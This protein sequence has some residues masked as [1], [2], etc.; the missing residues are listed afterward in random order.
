M[1]FLLPAAASAI[2][3]AAPTV[4]AASA[5]AAVPSITATLSSVAMNLAMNVAVSAAMSALQPQVGSAGRTM[6]WTLDPDGAIPFAFGRVG[7]AGSVVYRKTFGPDKMYLGVVSVLSGAGPIRSFQTFRGDE[8]FVTFDGA[9][10]A[11]SSQWVGEMWRTTRLGTQPDTALPVPIGLKTG[12]PP[13]GWT[14]SH[15]LS[16]KA[17]TLLVMG[18][19]SKRSAY[20]QGEVKPL[21]VIEGLFC[22]DPRQDSTYPG[23]FGPCRLSDPSTWPWVE[24][25]ILFGL[26][27]ALGLWEGPIGKGAPQVDHQ[28]GGIGAKLAGIDVGAFV[29]AA[30]VSDANG[31]TSAAYPTTA[32]DKAQVLD[33]FLQAGGAI[34]AQRAGKISCIQRAAPRASVATI[35]ARDVAG[36]IEID[37]A[38]SRIDRINTLRPR[39]WS[40]AHRWQMT[41]VE[42]V[43]AEAWRIEDGGVRPRGIDYPYVTDKDQVAQLAALQIANTREG[44]AGV[45]PLKPHL[46]R[47]RPGDAF[48]IDEP[49][50][51]LN[52]QKC[53]CLKTDYDPVTTIVRVTFVSE[54]DAKYAFALGQTGTPPPPAVL[55]PFDPTVTPPQPG[56]WVL[57]SELLT[58][59]GATVPALVLTGEVDNARAQSVIFEFQ[60][61]DPDN[62]TAPWADLWTGAG[63]EDPTVERKEITGLTPTPYWA[64]VSYRVGGNLSSRLVLGPVTA[65]A[66]VTPPAPAPAK[67]PGT[68][69]LTI[70]T[71]IQPDG[72]EVSALSGSWTAVAE[73]TTYDIEI[74]DGVAAW[75]ESRGT[76]SIKN[77]RV[78]TGRTYRIRVKA[79]NR[80]GV[81]STVWSNWSASVAAG[82]DSAGPGLISGPSIVALAR[83]LVLGWTNPADAD[84]SHL[85]MYRNVSGTAPTPADLYAVRVEGSTWTDTNVTAGVRYYYTA[86][87][88]D[89]SGNVG[90]QTY[91]G[92]AIPSYISTGGGDVLPTD[93]TLV[94]SVGT[95]AL[96][97]GQGT[98]ATRNSVTAAMMPLLS[99]ENDFTDED[100]DSTLIVP[101]SGASFDTSAETTATMGIKRSLKS[102]VGNGSLT[103]SQA[104]LNGLATTNLIPVTPGQSVRFNVRSLIKAGFTGLL[105]SFRYFVGPNGTTI[106]GATIDTI[107]DRRGVAQASTQVYDTETAPLLVPAGASHCYFVFFVDWSGSQANAGYALVGKP[108]LRRIADFGGLAT[109]AVRLGT[110]GNVRQSNGTTQVT[111][112][113]AITALGVAALVAGQGPL[114]TLVPPSYASDAAAIAAGRP[115]GFVYLNTTTGQQQSIGTSASASTVK[116]VSS[117]AGGASAGPSTPFAAVGNTRLRLAGT[118]NGGTLN[119]PA[120]WTGEARLREVNAG[121]TTTHGPVSFTVTNSGLDLGGGVYASDGGAFAADFIGT[122][123][124]AV[125]YFV[126][127][128][129]TGGATFNA[130]ATIA[131]SIDVT[132]IT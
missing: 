124:G 50:F 60:P 64:A 12:G 24:N 97:A 36:A 19:N 70:F 28:V 106:G 41:A 123:T 22:W 65:G 55:V 40:E 14:A 128:V 100:F 81:R 68:P 98:L 112:A 54:T 3:A 110:G 105:R 58:D 26:K 6:E 29:A 15:R 73:A 7:V 16:G 66:V 127:I 78:A 57:T 5:A 1:P 109:D 93:P 87:P 49:G 115:A 85:R 76:A 89:R 11:I 20:T 45:I 72:T 33:A 125:T 83:R 25:P 79:S 21:D 102:P 43:T 34:Y 67:V 56:E 107:V 113:T 95:A 77:L 122:R 92:S 46:Q 61:V 104:Q 88:V 52:G 120:N 103:P 108:R 10:R 13:F 42:E 130:G 84:Y 74:D 59:N 30:N 75:T 37:T 91:L 47:I 35:T 90:A 51:V 86:E 27:W 117:S 116:L 8:E 129:R 118:L 121:G 39:F 80:D 53:L 82:G 9:G 62:P 17:C 38:A 48:T 32:D 63:T 101:A 131:A 31:W 126:D 99:S 44:I 114:T 18:E 4:A 23:G 111:D 2:A 96:V 69:G 94:T 71:S 132:P 119:G